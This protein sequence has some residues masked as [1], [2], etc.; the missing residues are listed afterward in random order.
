VDHGISEEQNVDV[1]SARALRLAATAAHL[2]LN[3][4]RLRQ[5][6]LR[7]QFGA[8]RHRAVEEPWLCRELHRLR[9]VQRRHRNHFA[10]FGELLNRC[11]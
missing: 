3:G 6:Q 1:N 9:F 10:E 4:Q 11:S 8:Q 5:E 2:L 7:H